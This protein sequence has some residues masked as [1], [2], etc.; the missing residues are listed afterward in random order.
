M[1]PAHA[2]GTCI[3]IWAS[4]RSRRSSQQAE[5]SCTG[6][7]LLLILSAAV[8]ALSFIASAPC[9]HSRQA[10][11][12]LPLAMAVRTE[13]QKAAFPAAFEDKDP[14]LGFV[15]KLVPK[16]DGKGVLKAGVAG[17]ALGGTGILAFRLGFDPRVVWRRSQDVWLVSKL[18]W[19]TTRAFALVRMAVFAAF[20]TVTGSTARM[21]LTRFLTRF[22]DWGVPTVA[23]GL[24]LSGLKG[25]P[26]EPMDGDEAERGQSPLAG[27]FKKGGG[28]GG[29]ERGVK[30]PKELI[31][32][33]PLGERYAR[34]RQASNPRACRPAPNKSA[35]GRADSRVRAPALG[36]GSP[37]LSSRSR[38]R[39]ALSNPALTYYVVQPPPGTVRSRGSRATGAARDARVALDPAPDWST[40][41][42]TLA[43]V[44]RVSPSHRRRRDGLALGGAR[45]GAAARAAPALQ[46]RS[47]RAQR[48]RARRARRGGGAVE[49][50][51]GRAR[52]GGGRGARRG[53]RAVGAARRRD[54]AAR[55]R[56][57]GG[58]GPRRAAR[59]A[60]E[61]AR[62][63]GA[64]AARE[65]RRGD[66]I[67]AGGRSPP[68]C[69]APAPPSTP[70]PR[71]PPPR[72]RKPRSRPL[73]PRPSGAARGLRPEPMGAAP[74]VA[75]RLDA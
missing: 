61:G 48:Q 56:G 8:N 72:A 75:A 29:V 55:R 68:P 37:R 31:K 51:G 57:G 27:L 59:Q 13:E 66:P 12:P 5:S 60:E 17:L 21:L 39:R 16:V 14:P 28:G 35:R 36:A 2:Q 70:P 22:I 69:R 52:R 20:A 23:I 7:K 67:Y 30:L 53:A 43:C 62:Q 4:L 25:G 58:A 32:V 44:S 34:A 11:R 10:V 3:Y 73:G 33:E 41:P 1:A 40:P 26:P 15:T 74:A 38:V 46:R 24:L 54:D 6:M 45:G 18:T 64:R 49:A 63:A 47:G 9:V 71:R 65:R 42:R 50:R 19:A